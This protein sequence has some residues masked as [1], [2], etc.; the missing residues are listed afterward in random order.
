MNEVRYDTKGELSVLERQSDH[1]IGKT[2]YTEHTV[3]LRNCTC[4]YILCWGLPCRHIL[5]VLHRLGYEF[6][7]IVFEF[8]VNKFWIVDD[9]VMN[10]IINKNSS[11]KSPKICMKETD[12]QQ[13]KELFPPYDNSGSIGIYF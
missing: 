4:Q 12:T 1:G 3:S 8:T 10:R 5:A 6:W 2:S 9:H 11:T 13:K 7:E